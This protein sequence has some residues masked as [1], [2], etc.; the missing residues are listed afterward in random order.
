M[1]MTVLL[2]GSALTK[3]YG[4]RPLFRNI[5]FGFNDDERLGLIGPNGAG[6]STL[7]RLLIGEEKPDSGSV[8]ARKGL[9]LAFVPQAEEFAPGPTVSEILREALADGGLDDTEKALQIELTLAQAGFAS[10]DVPAHTLSGGWKKRLAIARA[11][12]RAPD[13][14]LM[15]EPTNHLDLRGVLWLEALLQAATFAYSVVSHD[16]YF[17]EHVAT[18]IVELNPAY[19]DGFLSIQGKYSDFLVKREEY[20]AAQAHQEVALKSQVTREI[21]WLRRGAQARTTKQQARI[22]Q[23]GQLIG[24]FADVKQRNASGKTAGISFTASGRQTRELMVAH[25]FGAIQGDRSLFSNLDLTLTPRQRLGLV[26]PNGSGK[27]TLLRILTGERDPDAGTVKRADGLRVVLFDQNRAHLDTSVT[28]REA[29]SPNGETVIYQGNPVH[30]SGWAKRFLF[31]SDQLN[32][33]LSRFSGGEQARVLIARL[34]LQPADVLILDEPTNDLDIPTLEILEESLS[35]FPGA[36]VLV[37]HDRYLLDQVATQVLALDG[38]GGAGFYADYS[39]WEAQVR[40]PPMPEP[41][42]RAQPLPASVS[43]P[44]RMT[45][46]ERREWKGIEAKIESAEQHVTKLK[47]SLL[48]PTIASDPVLLP[49][50][51]QDL[52]A[53]EAAVAT[54]YARW[55]ELEAKMG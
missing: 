23:A 55:E 22:Q 5:T 30:V 32:R 37:T 16:R 17:L 46:A 50:C 25:G 47:E 11:L 20:L 36:L 33:P 4:D 40:R 52:Q 48:D 54:V 15:D 10:G 43:L 49:Q 26:G 53:A 31:A 18:R 29:L 44:N 7:L 24:E 19:A 51:W 21:E 35:E 6:K 42:S 41:I 13:L 12:I 34:M 28:L 45:T 1:G 27:T 38:N 2:S 8:S 3:S 39:Q 14:I 9:R